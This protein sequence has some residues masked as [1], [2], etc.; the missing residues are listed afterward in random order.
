MEIEEKEEERDQEVRIARATRT[1][2][3][4]GKNTEA[5]AGGEP[6]SGPVAGRKISNLEVGQAAA[7]GKGDGGSGGGGL[8]TSLLSSLGVKTQEDSSVGA[9]PSLAHNGGGVYRRWPGI[10]RKKRT[11]LASLSSSSSHRNR[12]GIGA[13]GMLLTGPSTSPENSY[14]FLKVRFLTL[15]LLAFVVTDLI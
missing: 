10:N 8:W 6:Q 1:T 2:S 14:L 4:V 15:S 9:S 12:Q 5:E 7:P 11:N 3:K 13:V